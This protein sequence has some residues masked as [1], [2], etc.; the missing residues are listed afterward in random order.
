MIANTITHPE[1]LSALAR[2]GH[3]STVLVADGHWA[4]NRAGPRARTVFLNLTAGTPTVPEVTAVVRGTVH[5]ERITQMRPSPDSLPSEVQDQTAALFSPGV[6]R[7]LV[8]R[9]EFYALAGSDD[10]VLAVVTGDRR[11]FGNVLL[12]VGVLPSPALS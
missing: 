6:P 10:L 4:A 5:I 1:V 7:T 9:E 2:A 8:S 11:R 12:H 3:G